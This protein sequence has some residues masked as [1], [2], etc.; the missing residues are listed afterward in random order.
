ML[1]NLLQSI[2]IKLDVLGIAEGRGGDIMKFY[3]AKVNFMLATDVSSDA[4]ESTM[5]DG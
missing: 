4:I 2:D 3:Y 1:T 5:M